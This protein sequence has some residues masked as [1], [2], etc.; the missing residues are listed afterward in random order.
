M[1]A[2]VS[3]M[4]SDLEALAGTASK[5]ED[6]ARE[7]LHY[8]ERE[9]VAFAVLALRLGEDHVRRLTDEYRALLRRAS[10]M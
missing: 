5:I 10:A 1:F 8:L 2:S 6:V 9:N 4:K 7:A 3:S